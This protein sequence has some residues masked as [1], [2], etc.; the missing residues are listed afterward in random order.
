[1]EAA[2]W[3]GQLLQLG[4]LGSQLTCLWGP[5]LCHQTMGQGTEGISK[6]QGEQV[7]RSGVAT[8]ENDSHE[9]SLES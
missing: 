6:R 8:P 4:F 3:G 9:Q 7:S 5:R 2:P 1:M